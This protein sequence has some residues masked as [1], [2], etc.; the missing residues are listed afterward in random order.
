VAVKSLTLAR[1][2]QREA[3]R[4]TRRALAFNLAEQ[5]KGFIEQKPLLAAR[6]MLEA[7]HY[8]GSD[9]PELVQRA[10]TSLQTMKQR[11]RILKFENSLTRPFLIDSAPL[12]IVSPPGRP[13]ELRR[14]SDGSL[15]AVLSG[16]AREVSPERETSWRNKKRFGG[17]RVDS[18]LP[19]FLVNYTNGSSEF[20]RI[21]D[22]SVIPT[23]EK[24]EGAY[25]P[26]SSN[27]GLFVVKYHF[28]VRVQV[29]FL[30][31]MR[32]LRHL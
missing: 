11:A 27:D 14:V 25:Y 3:E 22:G 20:R 30:S 12:A 10:L 6:L 1:E 5:G 28:G 15:V 21:D 4:Q 16:I 2:R 13:S 23:R 29:L 19:L 17:F 18:H 32:S 9:D 8:A 31:G 24:P 7:M 26:S